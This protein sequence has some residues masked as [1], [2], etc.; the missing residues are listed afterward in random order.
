MIVEVAWSTCERCSQLPSIWQYQGA[1]CPRCQVVDAVTEI[2]DAELASAL[3]GIDRDNPWQMRR[4]MRTFQ[5]C[6]ARR[7]RMV[8]G[9]LM[10][11]ESTMRLGLL[12]PSDRHP[13]TRS[14]G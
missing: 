1:A 2:A 3:H 4:A 9:T 5:E 7:A 14:Q 11:A 6:A 13:A 8:A 10:L 12:V